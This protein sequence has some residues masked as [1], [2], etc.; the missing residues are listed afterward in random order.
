MNSILTHCIRQSIQS[1]PEA[2]AQ[3]VPAILSH[4]ITDNTRLNVVYRLAK[5]VVGDPSL[6][7]LH[8]L[9]LAI[10]EAEAPQITLWDEEIK[11]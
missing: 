3:E 2:A 7:N 1:N 6:P 5:V 4:Y 9:A 11:P 10:K 8:A